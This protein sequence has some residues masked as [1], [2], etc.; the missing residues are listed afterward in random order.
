V[1][2]AETF[3][4]APSPRRGGGRSVR[5]APPPV[6]PASSRRVAGVPA[7]A[8]TYIT[9]LPKAEQDL[10]E[11]QAA[12]ESLMLVV[13]LGG[14]TMLA[15]IGIMR[16]LN[17]HVERVRSIAEGTA[18]DLR[19]RASPALSGRMSAAQSRSFPGRS[20]NVTDE[21]DD[22]ASLPDLKSRRRSASSAGI[23]MYRCAGASLEVLLV[24]FD[25]A[26]LQFRIWEVESG[27]GY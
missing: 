2:D 17:R 22:Q 16:A 19:E 12:V 5:M 13:E 14:P 11:W 20:D 8:G 26:S 23:L 6:M 7:D 3:R 10:E 1:E 4:A 25:R 9:Q 21:N 24:P 27:L 18:P 15:R